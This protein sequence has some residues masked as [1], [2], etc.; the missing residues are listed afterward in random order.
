MNKSRAIPLIERSLVRS[1]G[2]NHHKLIHVHNRI[3]ARHKVKISLEVSV[4][5]KRLLSSC[6]DKLEIKI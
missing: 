1:V 3:A 4:V 5:S 6:L 2:N